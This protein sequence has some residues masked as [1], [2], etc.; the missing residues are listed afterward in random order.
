MHAAYLRLD[1][2]RAVR[3]RLVAGFADAAYQAGSFLDEANFAAVPARLL[4]GA[5]LK[6]DLGRGL[7]VAVEV[8]NLTD[9]RVETVPLDP[10]PRPDLA[11]IPRAI[12]DVGGY[13]LPGRAAYLRLD[14]SF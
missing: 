5:G 6:L 14:G 9:A 4:F 2:A 13:P 11:D 12:A 7:A 10:P 3:G 8:K 1:A